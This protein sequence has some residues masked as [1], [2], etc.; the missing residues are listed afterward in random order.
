MDEDDRRARRRIRRVDLLGL[1]LRDHRASI[2]STVAARAGGGPVGAGS[3]GSTY[4]AR[5]RPSATRARAPARRGGAGRAE[6]VG[7]FE[8]SDRVEAGDLDSEELYQDEF[9][10]GQRR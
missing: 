10:E 6:R 7:R 4:G 2:C 8:A 9:N 3:V 5:T 1:A